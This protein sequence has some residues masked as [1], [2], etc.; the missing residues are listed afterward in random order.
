MFFIT[1]HKGMEWVANY[2]TFGDV[3]CSFGGDLT[4]KVD[5][6]AS[7]SHALI[8]DRLNSIYPDAKW[9]IIES[10]GEHV[11]QGKLE[12]LRAKLS[13][14]VVPFDTLES[15]IEDVAKYLCPNWSCPPERHKLLVKMSIT[16]QRPAK[17]VTPEPIVLSQTCQQYLSV[18]KE[19]CNDDFAYSWLYQL[20]EASLTWDHL[21]DGDAVDPEMTDRV[22][23]SLVTQ[24]PINPFL[25]QYGG[26]I[27]P[28]LS[29][30][31]SAWKHSY[32]DGVSKD[33]AYQIYATA[34]AVIAF[35]LGGNDRVAK[36]MP[37]I[38]NLVTQM[39][40][41]DD[42]RDGGKR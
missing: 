14:M 3:I 23:T 31:I 34:P 12:E 32:N 7:S 25:K 16:S 26:F 20:I 13:P 42:A 28:A 37:T 15:S 40:L 24:W 1:G 11:L 22:F 8:Q 17:V 27:M 41:D 4:G 33:L 39:R 5:G 36:Y 30:A 10:N 38:N 35:I 2:L 6:D 18:C 21:V 29:S 19:M 9:V